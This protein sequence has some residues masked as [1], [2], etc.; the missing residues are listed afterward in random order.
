MY[1]IHTHT[2]THCVLCRYEYVQIISNLRLEDTTLSPNNIIPWH[3]LLCIPRGIFR[4]TYIF[5]DYSS[6]L[7]LPRY[8]GVLENLQFN[9]KASGYTIC[10]M[11]NWFVS[12]CRV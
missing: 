6:V 7:T 10:F 4:S 8:F 5:N 1:T 11:N 3:S 9:D 12:N 2:H